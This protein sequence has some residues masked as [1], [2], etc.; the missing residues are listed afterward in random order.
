MNLF[1]ATLPNMQFT[2]ITNTAIYNGDPIWFS[3]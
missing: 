3:P 1:I 2:R